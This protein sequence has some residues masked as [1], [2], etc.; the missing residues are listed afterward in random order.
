MLWLK[1]THTQKR[2]EMRV[3]YNAK[4]EL[5]DQLYKLLLKKGKLHIKLNDM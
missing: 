2:K 5:M 4:R 1:I 3:F